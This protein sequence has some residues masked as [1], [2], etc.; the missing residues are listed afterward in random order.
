MMY[1]G[2]NRNTFCIGVQ[3]L[4]NSFHLN[5]GPGFYEIAPPFKNFHDLGAWLKREYEMT[6]QK[7]FRSGCCFYC[8]SSEEP[9]SF[10]SCCGSCGQV[11]HKSCLMLMDPRHD[12]CALSLWRCPD[13]ADEGS[14]L[15][16]CSGCRRKRSVEKQTITCDACCGWYHVECARS[17]I[18]RGENRLWLCQKCVISPIQAA[19]CEIHLLCSELAFQLSQI[20]QR[21]Y[22]GQD[23]S[24]YDLR[25][26]NDIY[27][28][29]YNAASDEISKFSREVA[30]F[31]T[32]LDKNRIR[33]EL[34]GKFRKPDV[35]QLRRDSKLIA[36]VSGRSKTPRRQSS[37]K[38]RPS[39]LSST[40]KRRR[41]ENGE[42][43]SAQELSSEEPFSL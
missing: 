7:P 32:E 28:A 17:F 34:D 42:N 40:P 4:V 39:S 35:K 10:I 43:G 22:V 18:P 8:R 27:E 31:Y 23:I 9:Q 16:L 20:M 26:M 14:D 13:C 5:V 1:S 2:M 41:S 33:E 38:K 29:L 19:R 6:N 24:C 30:E 12:E 3:W 25:S 36:S 37:P 21:L 11:I 15:K